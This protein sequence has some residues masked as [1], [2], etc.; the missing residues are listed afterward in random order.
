MEYLKR[1]LPG[2]Q[3]VRSSGVPALSP[4]LSVQRAEKETGKTF[5][6]L[7]TEVRMMEAAN[8]LQNTDWKMQ[9]IAQRSVMPLGAIFYR[10]FRQKYHISPNKYRE[11]TEKLNFRQT[12]L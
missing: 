8:L 10:Q 11:N 9:Q 7:V 1:A 4:Q 12:D 2:G 5:K 6:E 3:L